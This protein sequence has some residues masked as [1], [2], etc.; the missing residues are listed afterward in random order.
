MYPFTDGN[1]RVGRLIAGAQLLSKG[2]PPCVIQNKDRERYYYVLQM[3]D[4]NRFDPI[5]QFIAESTMKGY[6]I[7]KNI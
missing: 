5:A 2:F 1:G 6:E 4:I 7:I 3:G